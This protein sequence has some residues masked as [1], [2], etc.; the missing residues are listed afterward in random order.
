MR[1]DL[2][3]RFP[4][5]LVDV[6]HVA[7][8]APDGKQAN[9]KHKRR[10]HCDAQAVVHYLAQRAQNERKDGAKQ[11]ALHIQKCIQ[12]GAVL[13]RQIA[14][15]SRLAQRSAVYTQKTAYSAID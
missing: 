11:S 13:I 4:L 9:R 5:A 12:L 14:L 1:R 6:P 15:H 10:T 7:A 3:F 8:L 2:F